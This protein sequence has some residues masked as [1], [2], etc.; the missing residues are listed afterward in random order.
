MGETSTLRN[1]E[2]LEVDDGE[3]GGKTREDDVNLL[4]TVPKEQLLKIWI[5]IVGGTKQGKVYG[6]GSRNLLGDSLNANWSE[7]IQHSHRTSV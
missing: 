6:V 5:E 4:K 7:S 1:E 2:G 3:E